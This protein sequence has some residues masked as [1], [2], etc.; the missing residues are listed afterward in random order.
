MLHMDLIR[1][2]KS[3]STWRLVGL[4]IIT[5]GVYFAHYIARQTR[6]INAQL[7]EE[8]KI[9][10]G[11]TTAIYVF[12]YGSLALFVGY[13]F[14]DENSPVAK[15]SDIVDGLWGLL[16]MI[17]GFSARNRLNTLNSINR[18]D[19]NWFHGFW[20]FLFSPLYF[21]YKVNVLNAQNL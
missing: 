9:S 16:L 2:L 3:Q 1:N 18:D 10:S 5:F 12:S 6:I 13:M 20:T 14:V 4:S 19:P 21:N 8:A 15:L 7:D 17:W 11:W